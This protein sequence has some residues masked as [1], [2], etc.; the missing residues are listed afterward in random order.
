[1]TKQEQIRLMIDIRRALNSKEFG[2]RLNKL[3][4]ENHKNSEQLIKLMKPTREMMQR[5]YDI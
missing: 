4:E 1:M 5:G 3:M 2:E